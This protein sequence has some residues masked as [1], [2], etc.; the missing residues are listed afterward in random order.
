MKNRELYVERDKIDI[1][2]M[3]YCIRDL[4][5]ELEIISRL[6]TCV[7]YA[8]QKKIEDTL[9]ALNTES[10]SQLDTYRDNFLH[11]ASNDACKPV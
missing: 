11:V 1:F 5:S 3:N 4:L 9:V 7:G 8:L 6:D 10:F 2:K